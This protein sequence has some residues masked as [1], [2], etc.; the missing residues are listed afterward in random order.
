M[1]IY[2]VLMLGRLTKTEVRLYLSAAGIFSCILGLGASFG[3]MFILGME[4]NQTHHILPFIAIG[5]GIDDMFVIME[6][7]HNLA[8]DPAISALSIPER[9]GR[10]MKHAGVSVT[11]TSITDVFAFG[12][13]ACTIMPGLR[14]FCVSAAICIAWIFCLQV[15][16]FIAW[17]TLDQRRIEQK[18]HGIFPCKTVKEIDEIP[19]QKI[20]FGKRVM[21]Y[22]SN[23]FNYW[24][25]KL[26]VILVSC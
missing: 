7:W 14:A 20:P 1:F 21:N 11:V 10:T 23:F 17:V 18:K 3:I 16:W 25:F 8:R 13:G 5:I 6:C 4:Y 15:S 19:L 26:S 9:M 24:A 12:I 2:T 22:Y